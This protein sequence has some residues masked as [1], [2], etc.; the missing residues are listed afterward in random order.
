MIKLTVDNAR[1]A[2]IWTAVCGESASDPALT[3]FYLSIGVEQLSVAP[4]A[5]LELRRTIQSVSLENP[6]QL[7]E[8]FL[9]GRTD[10]TGKGT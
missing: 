8:Q 3:N 10:L 1:S 5:V 7:I 2:G 6:A 9:A 4:A